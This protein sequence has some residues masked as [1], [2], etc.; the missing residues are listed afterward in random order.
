MTT[1]TTDLHDPARSMIRNLT[2]AV[3]FDQNV[4]IEQTPY[5]ACEFVMDSIGAGRGWDAVDAFMS[6]AVDGSSDALLA[7]A[8]RKFVR[9]A[10]EVAA[11]DLNRLETGE[12]GAVPAKLIRFIDRQPEIEG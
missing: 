4:V 8:V 12:N 11:R 5:R 10:I 2:M 7:D 3:R 1:N 9:D 6:A